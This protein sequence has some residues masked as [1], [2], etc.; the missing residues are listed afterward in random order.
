MR[1]TVVAVNAHPDDEALL[2]GG[3]LA[4][5]SSAGHRVILVTVTDGDVG[6]TSEEYA[7]DLGARRLSELRMS[8]LALGAEEVI[9]LGYSDS[10]MGP[11]TLPDPPGRQRLQTAP[12]DEAAERLAQILRERGADVVIGYDAAG[13]YGHRDHVAV[14][15]IVRSAALMAGTSRLLEATAPRE[16]IVATL[17]LLAPALRH[18]A[19]FSATQWG[20]AFTPARS[21]NHRVNIRSHFS[22]K[23]AALGAHASQHAHESGSRNL[24]IVLRLPSALLSLVWRYEYFVEPHPPSQDAPLADIFV[25]R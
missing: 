23:R 4:L 12:L 2:M 3:T 19:G 24:G 21:I 11:E 20:Q 13:G 15:H 16:P 8:A 22:A 25:G 14:H 1:H 17:R 10:G 18:R 5:A 6:L 9:H 7:E